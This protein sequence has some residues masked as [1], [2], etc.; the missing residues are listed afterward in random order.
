ME[1]CLGRIINSA[2]DY[3]LDSFDFIPAVNFLDICTSLLNFKRGLEI[4]NCCS[5]G[6]YY[7]IDIGFEKWIRSNDDS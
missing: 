6:S 7:L 3:L 1:R 2:I 4:K 5:A